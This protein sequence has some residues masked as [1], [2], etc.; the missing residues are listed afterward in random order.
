MLWTEK[1]NIGE[2]NGNPLQCSCLENPRDGGAWWAAVSGVAQS[3]T[4]LKRLSSSSS[5]EIK[6]LILLII[7]PPPRAVNIASFFF[8]FFWALTSFQEISVIN[9]F[10]RQNNWLGNSGLAEIK[11]FPQIYTDSDFLKNL[12]YWSIVD[13]QCC[14]N[15]FCCC[16]VTQS[17]LT[18]CNPMDC[19]TPGIPALHY[20]P[21]FAQTHVRWVYDAI[22]PS[23]PLLPTS[24]PALSLSSIRIFSSESGSLHQV[25]KGLELQLQHQSFQWI[26]RVD[27]L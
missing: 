11:S 3:R 10:N 4:R 12:L 1:P 22:Q 19:N 25:V 8:L 14:V 9:A 23:H 6:Q 20:L 21:K 5:R 17:W 18:L 27:F 24:P 15:V 16:S 26:F 2:G 7:L 13:L